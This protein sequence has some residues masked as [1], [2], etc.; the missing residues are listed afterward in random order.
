LISWLEAYRDNPRYNLIVHDQLTAPERVKALLSFLNRVRGKSI[1]K[2]SALDFGCGTGGGVVALSLHQC[3]VVG[4][5]ISRT[6][7]RLAKI[8]AKDCSVNPGFILCDG[9]RLPI[10]N[11]AFDI[12]FCDQVLE[13][14]DDRWEALKEICR[15]LDK[16]GVVFITTPNKLWPREVHSGLLFASWLPSK[17]L[18]WYVEFRNR[19]S[20]PIDGE[21][22]VK[23][24]TWWELKK[25]LKAL[26]FKI[27]GTSRDYV[28]F[29]QRRDLLSIIAKYAAKLRLPVEMFTSQLYLIASKET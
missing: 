25:T 26:N 24:L 4:I 14:V 11:N 1:R 29:R 10:R 23:L 28:T 7:I 12:C 8:R 21:W 2:A 5:D 6:F 3:E 9:R 20:I 17:V 18:K 22:D 15:I 27:V 16:D 13:H 19:E